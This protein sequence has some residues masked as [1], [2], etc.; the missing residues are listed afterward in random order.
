MTAPARPAA[1]DAPRLL[2]YLLW[3]RQTPTTPEACQACRRADGWWV[4]EYTPEGTAARYACVC[5]ERSIR[6]EHVLTREVVDGDL[7]AL[8]TEAGEAIAEGAAALIAIYR[9][10]GCKRCKRA[11]RE[12]ERWYDE[13]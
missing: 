3:L 11:A 10:C 13:G 4:S 7:D 5:G 2:A 1:P 6:A 12:V 9:T 8:L